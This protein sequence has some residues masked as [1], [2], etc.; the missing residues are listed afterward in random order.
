MYVLIGVWE[1]RR[2]RGDHKM[3]EAIN[4]KKGKQ[5]ERSFLP[6]RPVAGQPKDTDVRDALDL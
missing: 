6:E 1:G 5:E 2:G 4:R 3:L